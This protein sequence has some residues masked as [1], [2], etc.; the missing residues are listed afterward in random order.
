[1][2]ITKNEEKNIAECLESVCDLASEIVVVDDYSSDRTVDVAKKLGAKIYLR[3]F[4]SF[5]SQKR[6]GIGKTS[7][8]WILLL[9]ADERITKPLAREIRGVVGRESGGNLGSNGYDGYNFYFQSFLFGKPMRPVM[10]GGQVLLFRENKGKIISDEVHERV[11]V[12]GRV[13][14]LKNPLLHYSYPSVFEVIDKFNRYT[15]PEA[16][17]AYK[18]GE[19]TSILKIIFAIPR[20]FFWRYFVGGEWRDGI[21]G[22]ALSMMFGI[23]HLLVQLKLWEIDSITSVDKFS[24]NRFI[25]KS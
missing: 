13:G 10:S 9:D 8:Q 25:P 6:F 15:G 2:I 16:I 4:E 12:S 7:G 11:E 17:E 18:R 14:Q 3:K 20:V 1:M 23:Y 24:S 22:F 21:R 19:R 5:G